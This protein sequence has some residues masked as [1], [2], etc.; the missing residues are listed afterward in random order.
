[1]TFPGIK[2]ELSNWSKSARSPCFVCK[3]SD[4]AGIAG[5]LA[6]AQA[7][8]LS[9]MPH[10]AGHS[11]TDAALNTA[12]VVM[13]LTPMRQILSW[14]PARGILRAEPGVTLREML[15][16]TWKDGWW[17][18]V[19]PSTME[20]TL[21]GCAA[22]NVNGK[23]AWKN[24]PF[25]AVILSLDV[26][27]A[28]GEVRTLLPERDTQLF[29]AFVGSMGLLGIIT[30]ITVQLQRISSG[31][32]SVRRRN[33]SSLDDLLSRFAEEE[34][35]SDFMEAWLDGFASGNHLGRGHL[36]CAS[37]IQSSDA[38]PPPFPTPGLLDRLKT[39]LV[40]IAASLGRSV[41]LPGVRMANRVHYGR[42]G[43]STVGQSLG[44]FPYTY[45]PP[46]AF[47]GYHALLPQGVETFQAF[48]PRPHA[49]EIFKQVLRYSQ[50]QG[51]L[52]VWCVIKQHRCD[53]FLLSYQVDGFSLELNYPRTDPAAQ[54]LY[55]VLQHM[56]AA[57]IEAGGRFYLA[58]DHFLTHAQY[59]QSIGD[60]VVD[61]FL[62]LKQ[63]CDPETLLQSD[64][65]RRVFQPPLH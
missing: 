17:L 62:H 41:L 39:P 59:R 4:A 42:E 28:T 21:G 2:A 51:C 13:D 3:V 8:H 9:V 25:G 1:M 18:A 58:K 52:P 60:E 34:L 32:V 46:A 19:S 26:L 44:L 23:N 7:Q 35:G 40:S 20:V 47:T 55:P 16:V 24:G 14:D 54:T 65:F 45:W 50:Q 37:L 27:F 63:R 43:Q 61:A 31:Y 22:M 57:V 33:A 29:Y 48:V 30:S 5:A 10:G 53:P 38:A 11:Y 15:Q 64:L 12:G 6:A 49:R 56:I 36:T